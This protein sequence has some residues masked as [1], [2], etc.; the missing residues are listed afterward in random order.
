MCADGC[1]T[2]HPQIPHHPCVYDFNIQTEM[3]HTKCANMITPDPPVPVI[4][5]SAAMLPPYLKVNVYFERP[6]RWCI[7]FYKYIKLVIKTYF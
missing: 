6:I 4:S 1:Q 3:F 2:Q 5:L 7:T